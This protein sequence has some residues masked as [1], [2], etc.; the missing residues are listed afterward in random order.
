MRRISKSVRLLAALCLAAGAV[1]I[2][3][4]LQDHPHAAA[5]AG[6]GLYAERLTVNFR[7]RPAPPFRLRDGI[8]GAMLDPRSLR[9]HPYLVSFIYT[10]C[11]DTCPLIGTEIR[12]AFRDLGPAARRVRAVGIS[13]DPGGD[14]RASVRR[15]VARL[16]EPPQFRYLIGTR[17]QLLPVWDRYF[18]DAQLPAYTGG[19]H[20]SIIYLVDSRGMMRGSYNAAAPLNAAHIAHDLRTVGRL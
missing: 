17:A 10:H 8:G 2:P 7:G 4:G 6:H 15:W 13:V 12:Q 19:T 16:R 14:T 18:I 1:L 9:G 5:P 20:T 11:T 3:L